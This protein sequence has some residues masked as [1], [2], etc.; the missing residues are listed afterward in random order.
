MPVL[1]ARF[2]L[3]MA[4]LGPVYGYAALP[5]GAELQRLHDVLNVQ[6]SPAAVPDM[7]AILPPTPANALTTVGE[8]ASQVKFTLN[9]V[10]I[11]GVTAYMPKKFLPLF[12][13]ATGQE[14]TVAELAALVDKITATYRND[15]Y[16]LAR[17]VLPPQDITAGNVE[18]QVVEGRLGAVK[19]EGDAASSKLIQSYAKRLQNDAVLQA[20]SLE[21][22]L[23]LMNDLP[24]VTAKATLVPGAQTGDSDIVI[25]TN[26]VKTSGSYGASN[27]GTRYVGPQQLEGDV[28]LNNAYTTRLGWHDSTT[29]R[30]VQSPDIL[31]LTYMEISHKL[32]VNAEGTTAEVRA[33]HSLSQPGWSLDDLNIKSETSGFAAKVSHPVVRSRASNLAMYALFDWRDT[34]TQTLSSELSNDHLRVLRTGFD[35]DHLNSFGGLSNINFEYSR[36]LG[37]LGANEK[38]DTDTSRGRGKA[39]GFSKFKLDLAYLQRLHQSW[40]LLLAASG[41]YS[42]HALLAGEEF[43]VGGENFGRGY[44]TSEI[45]GDQGLAAK[46]EL[47]IN[48]PVGMA[49]LDSWQWFGFYDTGAVWQKD[50]EPL[51]SNGTVDIRSTGM[52]IRTRLTDTLTADVTF[53]KPL[54]GGP[55]SSAGDDETNMYVRVR[56]RF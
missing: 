30:I 24:G 50:R 18:I 20:S 8:A 37:A 28:T 43:G 52:G 29:A 19:L 7:P 15:G 14:L 31:N 39:M 49:Y 6:E 10:R 36:G 4:M 41:Q 9:S 38:T 32:P 13:A 45:T 11:H 22:Y 21:R 44:D 17:A 27:W 46:A 3:F 47:Q 26:F 2:I 25:T 55:Q 48:F 1:C 53:A 33:H 54:T 56:N 23:L 42:S 34:A 51:E 12:A 16:I 5:G 35:V 40:N